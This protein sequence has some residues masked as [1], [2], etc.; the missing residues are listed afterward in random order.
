MQQE[1]D[2]NLAGAKLAY[3]LWRPCTKTYIFFNNK[4]LDHDKYQAPDLSQILECLCMIGTLKFLVP[5][6]VKHLVRSNNA[7]L[8][9]LLFINDACIQSKIEQCLSSRRATAFTNATTRRLPDTR[10]RKKK[11]SVPILLGPWLSSPAD[12]EQFRDE[13]M[14][15]S[16]WSIVSVNVIFRIAPEISSAK[17]EPFWKTWDHKKKT[18]IVMSPD[19]IS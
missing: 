9:A 7:H 8:P 5:N 17:G 11:G 4:V 6:F 1:D 19:K 2:W 16:I 18:T 14:R 15:F 12:E 3:N 13:S 10:K